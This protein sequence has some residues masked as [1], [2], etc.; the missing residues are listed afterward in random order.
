MFLKNEKVNMYD[1]ENYVI[2]SQKFIDNLLNNL[3]M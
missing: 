3:N 1:D 2:R